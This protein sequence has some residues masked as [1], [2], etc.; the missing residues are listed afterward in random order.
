MQV[1]ELLAAIWVLS[2]CASARAATPE[3]IEMHVA[4]V[5]PQ[6]GGGAAVLLTDAARKK[7]LPVFVG[8]TEA[9]SINVRLHQDHY[10][11]PLTHDLIDSILGEI[12]A[13]IVRAQIDE[14]RGETLIG[15]LLVQTA[16]DHVARI[17][18][19]P[20]DAIALAL[21]SGLPIFVAPAVIDA[22][23][24][25]PESIQPSKKASRRLRPGA[26]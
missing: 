1:A 24:I 6:E 18:A 9:L 25:G 26:I 3:A 16:R 8:S 5:L 22:A 17:D 11:R 14:V 19:R 13:K 15:T 10:P 21:G 23:G 2:C 7:V 4:A 20:S 12:G